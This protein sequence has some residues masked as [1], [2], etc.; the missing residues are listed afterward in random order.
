MGLSWGK[1]DKLILASGEHTGEIWQFDLQSQRINKL[2]FRGN[3]C[4]SHPTQELC[5]FADSKRIVICDLTRT[6][7]LHEKPLL[8]DES[9]NGICWGANG[10]TLYA[11][12]NQMRLYQC[13]LE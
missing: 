13:S 1:N 12:S 10:N 5:A 9:I 4:E 6:A 7:I 3:C 2:P 11:V 8:D